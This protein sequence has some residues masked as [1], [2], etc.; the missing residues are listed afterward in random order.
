MTSTLPRVN[1]QFQ[2]ILLKGH[3]RSITTVKFNQDGD[4]LFTAAKD[5]K[6]TVWY[7]D[8]GERLGTFGPHNGAVW[9]LDPS[10]DSKYLVTAC[11]D[12]NARLF[13][14]NTGKYIARMPHKGVVRSVKWG[15]GS[16]FF[17]TAADPFTSRDLGTIS[18]FE[19][20]TEEQLQEVPSTKKDDPAPLHMPNEVISVDDNDKATCIG[21]TIADQYIMAGFD[22]GLVV[23]YDAATGKEI[24]RKKLHTDRVNRLNFNRDKSMMITASKDCS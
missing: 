5:N 13:E 22:S 23:K 16:Q 2:P 9:D 18:I 20:P 19:F 7:S 3:E 11:A 4:L 12:A 8:S 6:P 1:S 17:A 21:W 14:V 15:D 10:W 24:Q